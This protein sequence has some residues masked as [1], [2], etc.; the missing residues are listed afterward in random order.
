M[1]KETNQ[2]VKNTLGSFAGIF[3]S[4]LFVILLSYPANL[5]AQEG[6]K[7]LSSPTP[8]YPEDAKKFGLRGVVK[9]QVVVAPDGTIKDTKVIGGHP[10]LVVAVQNTLKK[11]KYVPASSE[12]TTILEFNFHP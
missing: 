9:V 4:I 5:S 7:V 1:L 12:T 10:M 3:L 8:V 11:W 6:R 2:L